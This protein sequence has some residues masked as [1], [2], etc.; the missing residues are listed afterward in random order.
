MVVKVTDNVPAFQ[1]SETTNGNSRIVISGFKIIVKVDNY[2]NHA[3]WLQ[4][5]SD[6]IVERVY[7]TS[8]DGETSCS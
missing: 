6:C 3:I 5:I 7:V 1:N 4:N 8:L 2:A